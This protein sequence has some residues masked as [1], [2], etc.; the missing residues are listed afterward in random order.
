MIFT[1]K[2]EEGPAHNI[3]PLEATGL[4]GSA[5]LLRTRSQKPVS[6]GEKL[7]WYHWYAIIFHTTIQR[8]EW[9]PHFLHPWENQLEATDIQPIYNSG[10]T[11]NRFTIRDSL[12]DIHEK[13]FLTGLF[14][15]VASS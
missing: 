9:I 15:A 11:S 4:P 1:I 12:D 14:S 6:H 7:L 13:V 8:A 3:L 2:Y 5:K 10:Q